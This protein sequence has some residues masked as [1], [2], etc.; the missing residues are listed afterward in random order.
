M[1]KGEPETLIRSRELCRCALG[2]V[3]QAG[4][5]HRSELAASFEGMRRFGRFAIVLLLEGGG[6]YTDARG[7]DRS[8]MAGD[9]ILVL[10]DVGHRYGAERGQRWREIFLVFD[11]PVFDQWYAQGYL[12]AERPILRAEPIDPWERRMREVLHPIASTPEH[13]LAEVCRVQSLLADLI[14]QRHD[15][16]GD[17]ETAWAR[18][19]ARR[20]DATIPGSVDWD[21]LARDM[22]VSASTLRR[23]FN[24][25]FGTSPSRYRN[26]RMIDRACDLMHRTDLTDQEIA[27]ELGFCDAFYFS[28]CFKQV[29][30]QS[31]REYRRSLP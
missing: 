20:I 7:V 14:G 1:A 17:R 13:A 5:Q 23:R 10:P 26:R 19:A 21:A 9:M 27:W 28:R 12:S 2:A 24:E 15:D 22:H 31:P 18:R 16:G 30:G 25:H 11:G 4:D 29:V 3:T 6:R 8:I